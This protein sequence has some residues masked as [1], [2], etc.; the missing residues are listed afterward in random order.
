M[1]VTSESKL[2][3]SF[4]QV[5]SQTD[6]YRRNVLCKV[7]GCNEEILN[8]RIDMAALHL[9]RQ[10]KLTEEEK[11]PILD[12]IS[13]VH[14]SKKRK[15]PE[16]ENISEWS[17]KDQ[18]QLNH[19]ILELIASANVPFQIVKSSSFGRLV[20]KGCPEAYL[21][22]V[23]DIRYRLLPSK[24]ELQKMKEQALIS[25]TK[26]W[27]LQFDGWTD[28]SAHGVELVIA[29][30]QNHPVVVLG[31]L[32]VVRNQTAAHIYENITQ[33]LQKW[34]LSLGK[35]FVAV[36]TDDASNVKC[37]RQMLA[38]SNPGLIHFQCNLHRI[39]LLL[40]DIIQSK[41]FCP[42]L[43][44]CKIITRYFK[45]SVM[46][47]YKLEVLH[48][49]NGGSKGLSSFVC[50]RW[51]SVHSTIASIIDN[52]V[53][54]KQLAEQKEF[55]KAAA[56]VTAII[57]KPN[58]FEKLKFCSQ[59]THLFH[60][61]FLQIEKSNTNWT[62][63]MITILKL[64]V[65]L[66]N[67]SVSSTFQKQFH[68]NVINKTNNRLCS[69]QD[70]HIAMLSLFLHPNMR[71]CYENQNEIVVNQILD[72]YGSM[73]KE[74]GQTFEQMIPV[75]YQLKTYLMCRKEFTAGRW[76]GSAADYWKVVSEY[77]Y[78]ELNK[79]VSSLLQATPTTAL[80]ESLF[81]HLGRLKTVHR[82]SLSISTM[83]D[84]LRIKLQSWEN[85]K[86]ESESST[87]QSTYG[88]FHES[89]SSFEINTDS[90]DNT[91]SS[92][93]ESNERIAS[94]VSIMD[95]NGLVNINL[96]E[97]IFVKEKI[98]SEQIRSTVI[99]DFGERRY[100]MSLL[101]HIE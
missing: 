79:F 25:T 96:F 5:T 68:H 32:P 53:A 95:F 74:W 44:S 82:A 92:A 66:K 46:H 24:A 48:S 76:H 81:S 70:N 71:L 93:E 56:A 80:C 60:T 6:Y 64:A 40:K 88:L 19:D 73:A 83:E 3:W 17:S 28:V 37:V 91:S 26:G 57:K 29:V 59:Y 16:K 65:R 12:Y 45:Q 14:R 30:H 77:R 39:N 61:A 90:E 78:D 85:Q 97:S 23:D 89:N 20:R 27:T 13:K 33:L 8:C 86:K 49:E 21:P 31:L 38:A 75:L 51:L 67:I 11:L 41:I 22:S 15:Q 2:I 35:S 9:A 1:P 55:S 98:Y 36:V 87:L 18:D 94:S 84:L 42:L 100:S 4:F 99:E 52:E 58:F 69:L 43:G 54:L 62:D 63:T 7:Q 10:C 101:A 34:K 50:T 47:K 72:H